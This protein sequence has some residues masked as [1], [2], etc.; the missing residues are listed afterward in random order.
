MQTFLYLSLIPE[1]LIASM[2]PPEQF[3]AYYATGTQKRSRGRALFFE[4]K[5]NFASD[6]L[7]LDEI[8]K[9]CVPHE[10]G[11][12]RKSSYL[13]IYRVLEHV[14][15]EALGKLYLIT[16]D[17]KMLALEP[18]EF[19]V[20]DLSPVHL[21]QEICPLRPRVASTMD[22]KAFCERITD[23]TSPVSVDKIVFCELDLDG[24]AEDPADAKA[25][26]LPYTGIA[27]LRDC[28][29]AVKSDPAKKT[30][31][32]VRSMPGDL[33]YRTVKHGFFVG[34]GGK[35]LYYPMPTMDQLQRE[36][37][38]WWRSAESSMG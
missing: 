30:K 26:N 35:M 1:S 7:K 4:V 27:H 32:V 34:G 36:Y 38:E 11:R 2:L 5:R 12:P 9:R 33:M 14:P 31:T 37:Y 20:K 10:D 19:D 25:D 8:E 6:Y 15:L 22:P 13:S 17:G 21:Y 23:R 24:L 16:D 3:G 28:L 18:Q 29:I